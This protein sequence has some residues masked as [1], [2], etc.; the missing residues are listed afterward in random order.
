MATT[1]KNANSFSMT[2][3]SAVNSGYSL[4]LI[5]NST[6]E[7]QLVTMTDLATMILNEI[8]NKT[9]TAT[10]L[11]QSSASTLPA[12][13]SS[14]NSAISTVRSIA[15]KATH[16]TNLTPY[17]SR[18]L[19]DTEYWK[20]EF[21]K[22][23][24]TGVIYTAEQL[25]DGWIHI[26]VDATG[27]TGTSTYVMDNV[28]VKASSSFKPDTLYTLLYEVR[29]NRSVYANPVAHKSQF[30][31]QQAN[32]CMFW[33]NTVVELLEGTGPSAD[34]AFN[35]APDPDVTY[36]KRFTKKTDDGS[37][38]NNPTNLFRMQYRYGAGDYI[39]LELRISVY[40][41]RYLGDYM[42]YIV[43]DV[44]DLKKIATHETNGLM[45][46]EDKRKLDNM[47]I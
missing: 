12:A 47:T 27:Y 44:F 39:D 15:E 34:F 33:G 23:T 46:A 21:N 6:N 14:L 22:G 25:G 29:N 42:P 38:T 13:I 4:M 40:E 7:G 20:D 43:S 37:H 41:G 35:M 28:S 18:S 32:D 9:F 45:S 17:G 10:E 36:R 31:I 26:L 24:T 2:S 19:D 30:Y 3:L 11:G 8:R 5:N 1:E 16:S